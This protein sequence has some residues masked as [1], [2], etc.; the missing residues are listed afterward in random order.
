VLAAVAAATVEGRVALGPRAGARV[1][2]CGDPPEEV[3]PMTL[4][5]CHAHVDGFDLHAG[6]VMRAGPR[7]RLERLCRYALRPP[8]AQDRLHVS[9]EGTI[10]LTLCRRVAWFLF[11]DSHFPLAFPPIWR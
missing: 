6:L 7:D 9:A 4:G 10:W 1:R 3:A 8:L 11:P 5:P 2:R